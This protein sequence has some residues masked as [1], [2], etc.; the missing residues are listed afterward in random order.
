MSRIHHSVRLV[1]PRDYG[2]EAPP[3]PVGNLLR[4]IPDA[5]R[6]A[7]LMGFVGRSTLPR[8]P[9]AWLA[10]ASDVRFVGF[11][12]EGGD[13][14]LHFEAPKLGEAAEEQYVQGELW[15]SRPSPE[16]TGF[17]LL[18]DVIS[19]V[20]AHRT[21]S[22]R[23][24]AQLLRRISEFEKALN[25]TYDRVILAGHRSTAEAPAIVDETTVANAKL[26]GSE[27]PLPQRVLLMGVL[28]MIRISGQGFEL[29]LSDG[30]KVR[31]VLIEGDV[32]A[33]KP[34]WGQRVMVQGTAIYR[35]SGR[36][37][38]IDATLV[39]EYAGETSLWSVIPP[40]RQ[41]MVETKEWLK[42]RGTATG[43]SAFYGTW[44]GEETDEEWQ[45][46]IE[47]LS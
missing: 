20:A 40:P 30:S 14:V 35:P 1:S 2:R 25:R 36:P 31:G 47:R 22:D 32:A 39:E 28:D 23:F 42:P 8:R 27:T 6:Q 45:E 10:A 15:P 38:R 3:A 4:Q 19:D 43:V 11:N 34:M 24:D 46:M 37:L 41:R 9:P 29:V 5:V 18:G 7:V 17:D 33:L 16:D 26:L 12:G 21:D 13:T 44:P